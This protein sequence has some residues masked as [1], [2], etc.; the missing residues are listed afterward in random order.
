[1]QHKRSLLGAALAALVLVAVAATAL[2][3]A[4]KKGA[5]FKGTLLQL[6]TG[7][8]TGPIKSGKFRAPVSFRVSSDGT[9]VLAFTYAE[10]GCFGGGGFGKHNPFTFP[11]DFKRFGPVSV[12]ATGAFSAPASKSVYK[13]SGGTG[14]NKYHD[15]TTTTSSLTGNFSTPERASGR[16]TFT[17]SGHYNGQKPIACGPVTV[18]FSA[19]AH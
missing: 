13:V 5:K 7:T 4:P 9:K 16:I 11:G 18:T 17:Q 10:G 19:K 12:S 1:M 8:F 6:S 2:A 14:K 3:A 15:V